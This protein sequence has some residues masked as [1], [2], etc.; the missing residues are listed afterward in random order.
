MTSIDFWFNLG[1]MSIQ[2]YIKKPEK[3]GFYGMTEGE[4]VDVCGLLE[5]MGDCEVKCSGKVCLI[6]DLLQWEFWTLF[7]ACKEKK[8]AVDHVFENPANPDDIFYAH[9]NHDHKEKNQ[10]TGYYCEIR[11][12]LECGT[13]S[14]HDVMCNENQ[15]PVLNGEV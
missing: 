3:C 2:K 13:F 15:C 12:A 14:A 1:S 11:M 9:I 8:L 10:Y 4:S 6:G 7:K 5:S